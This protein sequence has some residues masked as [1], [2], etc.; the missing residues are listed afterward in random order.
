MI[1]NQFEITYSSDTPYSCLWW[2]L[3]QLWALL[4]LDKLLQS[5][6]ICWWWQVIFWVLESLISPWECL[7]DGPW[8]LHA[9]LSLSMHSWWCFSS[10][11]YLLNLFPVFNCSWLI[12]LGCDGPCSY[13][14]AGYRWQKQGWLLAW[15]CQCQFHILCFFFFIWEVSS[16]S[17]QA[18]S[19]VGTPVHRLLNASEIT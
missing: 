19:V 17:K 14:S 1:T 7:E 8:G 15:L 12:S 3:K 11:L 6:E 13:T 5:G 10:A 2:Q 4:C 18:S 9:V 16:S